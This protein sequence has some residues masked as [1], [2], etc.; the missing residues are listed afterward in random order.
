MQ[1]IS[2]SRRLQRGLLWGTIAT[3]LACTPKAIAA[4]QVVLRYGPLSRTV[5][6]SDLKTLATTG[7]TSPELRTY[8]SLANQEPQTVRQAL[9][10]PIKVNVL[11]LDRLLNS[12]VGNVLLN[13][14]SEVIHTPSGLADQ[15]ALRSALILSASRDQQVTLMETMENYPTSAVEVEADRLAET[16]QRVQQL[17]E[18]AQNNPW[19]NR[20]T[21]RV[22]T[23][24]RNRR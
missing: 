15:Q 10:R 16:Y 8:L 3:V 23:M 22:R 6:V 7:K 12:P 14:V 13:Q 19:L 4:D 5:A 2:H 1:Q 17:T 21:E 11:T 20:V 18:R 24:L 9:N